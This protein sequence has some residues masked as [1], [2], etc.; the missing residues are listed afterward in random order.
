MTAQQKA[1]TKKSMI[2]GGFGHDNDQR[3]TATIHPNCI[4]L[5]ASLRVHNNPH[6]CYAPHDYVKNDHASRRSS[7]SLD[8]SF[9]L[10]SSPNRSSVQRRFRCFLQFLALEPAH[11]ISSSIDRHSTNG[12]PKRLGSNEN[13]AEHTPACRLQDFVLPKTNQESLG[14]RRSGLLCPSIGIFG[15]CEYCLFH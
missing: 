7:S 11:S 9:R 2:F 13:I 12:Y 15:H 8:A 6:H 5:I 3:L 14:S 10:W 4:I 1:Q